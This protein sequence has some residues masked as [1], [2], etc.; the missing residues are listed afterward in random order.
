MVNKILTKFEVYWT[1]YS[2]YNIGM[3]FNET[4]LQVEKKISQ[5]KH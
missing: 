4:D 2:G 1:S 3:Q 5:S